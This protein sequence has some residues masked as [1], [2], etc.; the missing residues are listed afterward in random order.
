MPNFE[1]F[2]S[3]EQ[4]ARRLPDFENASGV[5]RTEHRFS[6]EPL[7]QLLSSLGC[8][9][10]PLPVFQIVGSK[11]KGSVAFFLERLLRAGSL[12]TGLFHS[13]HIH[14]RRERFLIDGELANEVQWCAVAAEVWQVMEME[15][16]RLSRFE[17]ELAIS[18]KLFLLEGVNVVV[19]EAGLGGISDATSAIPADM[20]LLASLELEHTSILGETLEDIA[21]QKIGMVEE[22]VPVIVGPIPQEPM[23]LIRKICRERHCPLLEV[24]RH[25]VVDQLEALCDGSRFVLEFGSRRERIRQ[26]VSIG[27]LGLHQAYSVA[28]TVAAMDFFLTQKKQREPFPLGLLELLD[29]VR[30]PG[31]LEICSKEPLLLVDSA[32]TVRSLTSS[33]E[34]CF[35]HFD[36]WPDVIVLG[37]N[38]DKHVLKE[39]P[40]L[41][42]HCKRLILV[43]NPG[44]RGCSPHRMRRYVEEQMPIQTEVFP[45]VHS[46]L[47]AMEEWIGEDGFALVTGSFRLAGEA[48]RWRF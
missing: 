9:D 48:I 18:L 41:L 16:L 28:I 35:A 42:G 24:G 47:R 36:R 34:S 3:Y 10:Y 1:D 5:G 2:A 40:S 21:Y 30:I 27:V 33:L 19:L 39:L 14:S 45:D 20:L 43:P 4:F 7:R 29:E 13:P 38:E 12:R 32:H 23:G 46:G 22:G 31:R 6:L 17:L 15:S 11:G 37:L 25:I 26:K 8:L 44:P